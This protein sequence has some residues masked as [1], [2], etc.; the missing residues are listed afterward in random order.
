MPH[1]RDLFNSII[2]FVQVDGYRVRTSD[3]VRCSDQGQVLSAVVKERLMLTCCRILSYEES[4]EPRRER[5]IRRNI[6]P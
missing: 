1:F 3:L 2:G 6:W 4:N 5:C